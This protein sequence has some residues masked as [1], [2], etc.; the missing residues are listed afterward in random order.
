MYASMWN[1]QLQNLDAENNK[2]AEH[3]ENGTSKINE[4]TTNNHHHH[5]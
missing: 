4:A 1:Q 2:N 3:L 5:H